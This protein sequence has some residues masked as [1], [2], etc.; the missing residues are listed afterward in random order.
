MGA[1]N[2]PQFINAANFT[3]VR[4][5][6][7]NTSSDGDGVISG[8]TVSMYVLMTAGSNGSYI[9]AVAFVPTASVANTSTSATVC[10]VFL[11][12]V[13]TG[14]TTNA[15]TH[16]IGEVAIPIVTAASST[17]AVIPYLVPIPGGRI[18]SGQYLLVSTHAAAAANTAWR[19]VPV[20]AGDF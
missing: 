9:E 4:I 13:N 17:Q 20:N 5:A 6:L 8:G 2:D 10:R 1:N 11:S 14:S 19:A 3:P 18:A 16:L 15:N 7:A 12:S